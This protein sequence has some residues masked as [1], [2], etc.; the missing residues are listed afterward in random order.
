MNRSAFW[1][2]LC[3]IKYAEDANVCA[4]GSGAPVE[5]SGRHRN[6]QQYSKPEH[7]LI[8][9]VS[10]SSCSSNGIGPKRLNT[11]SLSPRFCLTM[12]V[13]VAFVVGIVIGILLPSSV[14]P[15]SLS[16]SSSSS[17][18]SSR[19]LLF[20]L[21]L[22]SSEKSPVWGSGSSGN[23][24]GGVQ[25]SSYYVTPSTPAIVD[26]AIHQNVFQRGWVD[27]QRVIGDVT[28]TVTS[29]NQ[30]EQRT[31]MV[32][33]K[34]V[35]NND[36]EFVANVVDEN[37][38]GEN[39]DEILRT[40]GN[41]MAKYRW[42]PFT[43]ESEMLK[44]DETASPRANQ[45]PLVVAE[46]ALVSTPKVEDIK[47]VNS[48]N[49]RQIVLSTNVQTTPNSF[50]TDNLK[51]K[52]ERL[53]MAVVENGLNGRSLGTKMKPLGLAEGGGVNVEPHH[54]GHLAFNN[55]TDVTSQLGDNMSVAS[56]V[57]DGVFWS[58][59][60]E[61]S[62]PSGFAEEDNW[63]WTTFTDQVPV[64]KVL[65][66]CGRMQ[67]RLLVFE[68]GTKAC[69]RYRQNNDQIQGE[70]FS[71]YLAHL[72]GLKNLPPATLGLLFGRDWQWRSVRGQLTLA[73]WNEQKPVVMTKFVDDLVPAFI[74]KHFRSDDR[75]LHPTEADLTG[76]RG[77]QIIELAQWS[78]LV[79]FDYLTANLDRVVNNMY[80]RQWNPDMMDSPAHNLAKVSSTGLLVFL[81][82]ESGLLHGYR[83]LDKYES[84][85]KATLDALCVFRRSTVDAIRALRG[86]NDAAQMGKLLKES[87]R[88]RQPYMMDW[89]PLL[90]EKSVKILR[91]RLAR[92]DQQ[93]RECEK[94][95]GYSDNDNS[96]VIETLT[97]PMPTTTQ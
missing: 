25:S 63:H 70:I 55:T 9:I 67:N 82:N 16:S 94:K 87:L 66:G 38:R 13:T 37:N 85:H 29:N 10:G 1:T 11:R 15:N 20:P 79:I 76:L 58:P 8:T 74:P 17:T 24:K 86:A 39:E 42:W 32:E 40:F 2:Q 73:Q 75:Q 69:C 81:D 62:L 68:N 4:A 28:L 23:N 45:R 83:L 34:K 18:S 48:S 3:R 80:N 30:S 22:L 51:D 50:T 95:F 21:P 84:Y 44:M 64:V 19:L 46:A 90:P 97:K 53:K 60:V 26:R 57:T 35:P 72:L 43:V 54:Q 93:V 36:E 89:L 59:V 61:A 78:D 31:Q 71:F 41:V 65:D 91:E 52:S 88:N 5:N 6:Y 33:E 7:Q 12:V 96:D 92:V 14:G 27:D 49:K 77:E 56:L 47:P